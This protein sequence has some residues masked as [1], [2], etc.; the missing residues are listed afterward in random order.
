[1]KNQIGIFTPMYSNDLK[2]ISGLSSYKPVKVLI[3]IL[4]VSLVGVALMLFS[5]NT[6][7]VK[8][9]KTDVWAYLHIIITF[10]I[11]A[12]CNVLLDNIAE[13]FLPLPEKLRFRILLHLLLSI[14]IGWIAVAYYSRTLA[15]EEFF[16]NPTVR[17]L[18]AFGLVFV[19]VLI[20]V[21][22][23]LR[24][25]ERFLSAQQE[26]EALRRNKL[27]SD[28]NA[29]QDQLN[30][31]F[32]FNNLSV[33]KSMIIYDQDAAVQFTQNFTDVYRYVLKSREKT[34]VSLEDEYAFIKAYIGLHK[35]R[36]GNGLK[37]DFLIDDGMLEKELPPLAL[38]LLVENA[39]KHNIA[40]KD[41]VLIISI[42]TSGNA[43][44]VENNLQPK[45]SSYSTEMGLS[46]LIKRYA[47][48]SKEEVVIEKSANAFKVSVPLL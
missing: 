29:L 34:M 23:S 14:I 11:I 48:L 8:G 47:L 17:L 9:V 32:L 16:D 12:E 4:V 38:Q 37:V 22:I 41:K 33:L 25:V 44:V 30:P 45:A 15:R 19:L 35:E 13:R 7:G 42:K 46:N 39:I 24:I 10:N 27:R 43:L 5:V 20:I 21:A 1:M 3:R 31:H 36:L 2:F 18:F 6:T 28:Y 26:I 40:S